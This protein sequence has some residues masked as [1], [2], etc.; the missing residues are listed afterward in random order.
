MLQQL[1]SAT[2]DR[3][4]VTERMFHTPREIVYKAWTDPG[5]LKNW[6]GPKGFTNSFSEFDLKPGGRWKFIM[7]GPDKGNYNNECIFLEVQEP[8]LLAWTRVSKPHFH[9][10][11]TFDEANKDSTRLVFRMIFDSV[12]E[13]NKLRSFVPEKN[14]ENM[15]RLESE[16]KRMQMES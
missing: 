11:V 13:S 9:V 8:S 16:L 7:H 14:E 5:H 2:P 12:E 6:W 4:I 15:D 10:L 3:M 1:Q